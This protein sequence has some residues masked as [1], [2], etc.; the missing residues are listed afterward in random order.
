MGS[1]TKPR[2]C[3]VSRAISTASFS[4]VLSTVRS[5]VRRDHE[6]TSGCTH[7]NGIARSAAS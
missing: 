7:T 4:S 2:S 6:V 1:G 5:S 3:A